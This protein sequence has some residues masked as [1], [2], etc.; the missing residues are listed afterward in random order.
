MYAIYYFVDHNQMH[1]L[2][3]SRNIPRIHATFNPL[4]PQTFLQPFSVFLLL[5]SLLSRRFSMPKNSKASTTA[6]LM[7][8]TRHVK[9]V[10]NLPAPPATG[11]V[12]A[13]QNAMALHGLFQQ[14]VLQCLED[15]SH[16]LPLYNVMLQRQQ[17]ATA[18]PTEVAIV[19]TSQKFREITT[20]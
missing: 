10:Q 2:D 3:M 17:R 18:T 14:V 7:G 15:R 20:T 8:D 6:A 5:T 11:H 19:D 16:V 1:S 4:M 12:E 9:Y 13:D